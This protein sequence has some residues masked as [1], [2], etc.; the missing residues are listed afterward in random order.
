MPDE[1]IL[2]EIQDAIIAKLQSDAWFDPAEDNYVQ[3]IAE[4]KG[5]IDNQIT[6][7][8]SRI[9]I[10]VLVQMARAYCNKPN[11]PGPY[12]D[13]IEYIIEVAEN[14]LI[15]RGADDLLGCPANAGVDDLVTGV[16]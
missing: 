3:V 11:I 5:D 9:G 13:P 6:V 4:D 1:T 15:N 12:F 7:A 16:A 8:L 14:V 2:D 10:S